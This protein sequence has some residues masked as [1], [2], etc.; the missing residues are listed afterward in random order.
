MYLAIKHLHIATAYLTIFLFVFRFCL[1]QFRPSALQQKW[2]KYL[3]HLNDTVLFA[4]GITLVLLS[5]FYPFSTQGMW[6][7]EKLFLV[8]I[9]I[10]LGVIALGK[11]FK[12]KKIYV[13]LAFCM[14]LLCLYFIVFLAKTKIPFFLK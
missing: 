11:R 6:L 9:Y 2:L 8:L 1:A 10:L 12:C 3:P 13:Y 5:G 14:A 7:T 4:C